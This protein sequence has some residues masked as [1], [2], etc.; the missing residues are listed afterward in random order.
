MYIILIFLS[1]CVSHELPSENRCNAPNPIEDLAW[2]K[3]E[4]ADLSNS[5][6]AKKYWFITQATFRQETVFIVRNC[7]PTCNTLP[8]PVY[9]CNGELLFVLPMSRTTISIAKGYSGNPPNIRVLFDLLENACRC[10]AIVRRQHE[11]TLHL[12]RILTYLIS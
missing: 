1:A 8:S 7:C 5:D 12:H 6:L 10:S 3:A 4:V 9:S 2:L 11:R